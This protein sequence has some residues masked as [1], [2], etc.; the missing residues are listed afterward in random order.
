MTPD[1]L[2][3][4][5][6]PRSIAV[7]GASPRGGNFGRSVLRILREDEFAGSLYAVNPQYQDVDGIS[8]FSSLAALPQ[9]ADVAVLAVGND[10]IEQSLKAAIASK[11]G[12]AVIYGSCSVE[13][14]PTLIERLR[15]IATAAK[16]PVCGGNS[17]GFCNYERRLR[18]TAWPAVKRPGGGVTL[19]A[20]SGSVFS[21]M[22]RHDFRVRYNLAISVGQE[23]SVSVADYITYALDLES[24][25]AIAVFIEGVRDPQRFVD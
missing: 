25:K 13:G 23:T 24:T 1:R 12:S 22:T 4:L 17:A 11:A 20:H 10:R 6:A 7:V 2:S 3:P 9:A 21:A 18:L 16:L 19:L 5:L 15:T 14:D 8:C